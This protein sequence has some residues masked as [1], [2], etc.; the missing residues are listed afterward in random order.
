MGD[1]RQDSAY[2]EVAKA[3]LG[4]LELQFGFDFVKPLDSK[5]RAAL[6]ERAFSLGMSFHLAANA[7]DFLAREQ[8]HPIGRN[9]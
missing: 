5:V 9:S 1:R 8:L 6:G 2:L 4:A 7:G 3:V